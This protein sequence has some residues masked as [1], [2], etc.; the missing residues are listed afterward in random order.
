MIKRY[1]TERTFEFDKEGR[2]TRETITE[3]EEHDDNLYGSGWNYNLW[4]YPQFTCGMPANA[5]LP[6]SFCNDEG[7]ECDD[8]GEFEF[9]VERCDECEDCFPW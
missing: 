5:L 4:Q 3:T 6:S 2:I 7:C 9:D 1:I 8:V